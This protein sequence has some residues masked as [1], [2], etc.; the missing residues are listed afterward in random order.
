MKKKMRLSVFLLCVVAAG[1][2]AF[3]AADRLDVVKLF[4]PELTTGLRAPAAAWL[5]SGL[6]LL[7]DVRVPPAERALELYDPATKTKKT[8]LASAAFGEGLRPFLGEAAPA[9]VSWPAAFSPSGD[10][11]LYEIEGDVFAWEAAAAKWR[12]L[13]DTPAEET[14]AALSPDGRWASFIRGSDIYGVERTTGREVRLT[15]GGTET[16]LNGPLSWVYWEEIYD[17]AAVP[18]A[19]SPDSRSI[20]YL[21]TDDSRVSVSTF[22]NFE[23]AT[24]GVVRQRYPKAGQANPKVSLMV[25]DLASGRTA[26]MDCGSYEYLA[27]FNWLPDGRSIAVQTLNR[28]QN[29][30]R[31][32][33]ADAATGASRLVLEENQP[34]WIDL[35]TALHFFRDGRRFLWMSERDGYQHLYLYDIGGRLVRQL[36]R[37]EFMVVSANGDTTSRN[38]GLVAVDEKDGWIYFTSNKDA[39]PERHLYR[40]KLDGSGLA[41]LSREPGIHAASFAPSM[42]WYLDRHSGVATPPELVLRAADGKAAA[43]IAPPD[44][45]VFARYGLGRAELLTYRADDGTDSTLMMRKPAEFDPSRRYPAIVY[46]YGGPGSQHTVNDWPGVLWDDLLVQEGYLVFSVEVRA[47]LNKSKALETSA[48]RRAYGAQN[49]ADILAAV[50]RIKEFPFVDGAR[51]GLWGGSGGGCTTLFT[52]THCDAFKAAIALYPVSDWHYYDTIYTERYQDTPQ[53]NPKGYEDTSSVLAA[54][55]LKSRLLIIHGTY[56]DNV[57]PQNTEAFIHEL[58]LANIPVEVMIYPW[59]KH[60]IEAQADSI[61]HFTLMLDFWKR[62]L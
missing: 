38:N 40:V 25:V 21:Q 11:L 18:Y 16:L 36:T 51:L 23:P 1:T 39:L 57:H 24:Q 17:H 6:V 45:S 53:R 29:H 5:D 48:Y 34:A 43:V 59:Q 7:L 10:V 42:R 50:R 58:I 49:V 12:R 62:H 2:A 19:W 26:W 47:G 30:L 8:L 55:N 46:V 9:A 4:S 22:V 31:L 61:H 35:N 60:G 41:R 27:R 52:T 13:T 33:V 56:D 20:A 14:A 37:G 54:K 3:P 44:A 32:F 15:W 28:Q